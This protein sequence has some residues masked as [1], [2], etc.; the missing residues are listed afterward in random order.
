MGKAKWK[1]AWPFLA[2]WYA[3]EPTTIQPYSIAPIWP[4]GSIWV[5]C[6]KIGSTLCSPSYER[7]LVK[8]H[9]GT[10]GLSP[11]KP[12]IY[13]YIVSHEGNLKGQLRMG[14]V[15]QKE[16]TVACTRVL[17][18]ISGWWYTYPSEKYE[19]VSW[20]DEIP[21]IWKNQMHVPNHQP[22]MYTCV[23]VCCPVTVD[24]CIYIYNIHRS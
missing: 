14:E 5:C 3:Q 17:K 23:C 2:K 6:Q 13:T 8:E 15:T 21:N 20:N 10:K 1:S 18:D 19:F 11:N 22:D 16:C 9:K 24:V 4:F 7:W 12:N